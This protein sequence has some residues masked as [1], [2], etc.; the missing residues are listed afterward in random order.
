MFEILSSESWA[1]DVAMLELMHQEW[2]N[3]SI[4]WKDGFYNSYSVKY[5]YTLYQDDF[6]EVGL[7]TW[8]SS[9]DS[10]SELLVKQPGFKRLITVIL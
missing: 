10:F 3:S 7:G 1:T 8:Q 9:Q 4:A 5:I 2:T 6:R